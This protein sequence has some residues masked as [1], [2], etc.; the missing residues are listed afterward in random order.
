M[1][2]KDRFGRKHFKLLEEFLARHD[3]VEGYFEPQTP[4]MP[5]S[6][7]LVARDGQW[8]RIPIQDRRRAASICNK[9]GIPLYDAAVVGYPKRMKSPGKK[10][11][12]DAPSSEELEEWFSQD[13]DSDKGSN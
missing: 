5:Q 4:T 12:P 2:F 11:G 8:E 6:L 13:P 10:S 1:A 9:S 7:L 3:G